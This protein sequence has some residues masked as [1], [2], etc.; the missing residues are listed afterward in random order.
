VTITPAMKS[1]LPCLMRAHN[2]DALVIFGSDGFGPAK[3]PFIYFLGDAHVTIGLATVKANG[4][5][6]L[7][8][9]TIERDEA[10]KTG[11]KLVNK[12]AYNRPTLIQQHGSNRLGGADAPNLRRLGI[13]GRVA[14]YGADHVNVPFSLLSRAEVCEVVAEPEHD[15]ISVARATKDAQEVAC[16]R[17]TCWLTIG[18]TRDYLRGHRLVGEILYDVSSD[19]SVPSANRSLTPKHKSA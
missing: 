11:L 16:I 6:Y 18:E 8:H 2:L 3:A 12:A 14:F 13:Q 10:D 19:L 9:Y 5:A 7:V 4:E 1:D 17:Q 15:V